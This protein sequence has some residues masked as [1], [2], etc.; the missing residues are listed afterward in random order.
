MTVKRGRPVLGTDDLA[1]KA[2]KY[3]EQGLTVRAIAARLGVSKS[4]A[5][6]LIHVEFE[7]KRQAARDLKIEEKEQEVDRMRDWFRRQME[8]MDARYIP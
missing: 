6:E 2:Q 3:R 8:K 1:L 7:A 5:G 4:L